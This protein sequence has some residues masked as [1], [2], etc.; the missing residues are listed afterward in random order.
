M[1]DEAELTGVAGGFIGSAE[2]QSLYGKQV[3]D[4]RFVELLYQNVLDR[5]PE[6]AGYD[7][8]TT[9]LDNGVSREEILIGFSEST[10]NQSNVFP[11]ISTG[12]EYTSYIL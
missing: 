12:I 10:E 5:N 9:A 11:L 8:W 1:D 3:S 2:F 7:F 6:Q 4:D